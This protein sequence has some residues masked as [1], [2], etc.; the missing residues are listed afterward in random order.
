[1]VNASPAVRAAESSVCDVLMVAI[2]YYL[3]MSSVLRCELADVPSQYEETML[4]MSSKKAMRQR[5]DM[6]IPSS[7]QIHPAPMCCFQSHQPR[8]LSM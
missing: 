7:N 2:G 6:V 8:L 3:L 1:M 5:L 4:M